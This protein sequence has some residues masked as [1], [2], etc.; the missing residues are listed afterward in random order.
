[1]VLNSTKIDEFCPLYIQKLKDKNPDMLH[2]ELWKNQPI[3]THR[4]YLGGNWF[5]EERPENL[6]NPTEYL[7]SL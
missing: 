5:T 3:T 2:F 7:Y 1:M 6:M 4:N